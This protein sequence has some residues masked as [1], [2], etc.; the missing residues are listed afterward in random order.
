MSASPRKKGLS[1]ADLERAMGR[2]ADVSEYRFDPE[3]VGW[4]RRITFNL[5]PK[6]PKPKSRR[7]VSP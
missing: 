2:K 6:K 5:K 4:E 7:K 3:T 1:V